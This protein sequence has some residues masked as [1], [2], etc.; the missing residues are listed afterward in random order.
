MP[1][2]DPQPAAHA[3]S[4]NPATGELIATYP[5]QT[6]VEVEDLLTTNAAAASMWRATPMARRDL[7]DELHGQVQRTIAA[8]ATLL[9][10]GHPIEGTGSFYA[11]TVLADVKPGMASFDEETFGPVA[12]IVVAED[13]E[14]AI[15]LANTSEY[16]LGG[17]LWT[18]DVARAQRVARRLE[19]GGVF[20]NGYPASN[21][22]IPV[23]GVKKS[24]YG[25]ELSHFGLRE[26]TNV[27][28]VWAKT[29]N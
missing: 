25:R 26:F 20:I 13:A 22:R 16:G 15:E 12:S 5:F 21:A 28:A 4:R 1:Q 23:G 2:T 10:G 6:P 7:R 18:S 11:P 29:V 8:G 14:H 9:L 17:S 3:V 27:Q 19:T 24:G